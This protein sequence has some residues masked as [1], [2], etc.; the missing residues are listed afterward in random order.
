MHF[1][2]GCEPVREWLCQLQREDRRQIGADIH[3]VQLGWPLGMPLV[4]MMQGNVIKLGLYMTE[5]GGRHFDLP[6]PKIRGR[7]SVRT[8]PSSA[9][10]VCPLT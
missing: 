9:L 2:N 3:T 1:S 6:S 10:R 7:R 4:R 5:L 8:V